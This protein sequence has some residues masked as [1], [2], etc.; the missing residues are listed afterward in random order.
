MDT[1]LLASI[2]DKMS[3]L[4]WLQTDDA[5][6]GRNRPKQISSFFMEQQKTNA[7]KDVVSFASGKDF[8]K[9]WEDLMRNNN[10]D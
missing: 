10:G 6:K 4:A 1:F 2:Y 9:A 8:D 5:R 3:L 7:Q